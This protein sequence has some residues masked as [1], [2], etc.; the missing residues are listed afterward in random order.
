MRSA[1]KQHW[2]GVLAVL[3]L[4]TLALAASYGVYTFN[5]LFVPQW[6]ALVSAAAFELTYVG[7]AVARL[8]T[9][10]RRRA[11]VIAASAVVVSILYNV[12][13]GLF[14]LRP[15][16]LANATLVGAV[17]LAI[18]HGLPLAIVAYNV[19]SLLLHGSE[20]TLPQPSYPPPVEVYARPA[21]P[22]SP[23]RAYECPHCGSALAKPGLVGLA[24]RYGHCEACKPAK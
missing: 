8:G 14:H 10:Q 18:L 21:E 22:A 11:S 20:D 17:V 6:V 24:K 3:P 13:A 5:L 15:E 19:A 9:G 12:A 7:L 2:R 16:L 23:A 1:I 4:P